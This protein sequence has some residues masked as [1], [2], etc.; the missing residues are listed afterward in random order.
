MQQAAKCTLSGTKKKQC[1]APHIYNLQTHNVAYGC[2]RLSISHVTLVLHKY[3]LDHD[4]P[5]SKSASSTYLICILR[6]DD[7][8]GRFRITSLEIHLPYKV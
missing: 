1:S 2:L 7:N 5:H 3:P 8:V 4:T 6:S